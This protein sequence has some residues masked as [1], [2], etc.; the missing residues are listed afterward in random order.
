MT[1]ETIARNAAVAAVGTLCNGGDIQFQ[2]AAGNEVATC[3][4]GATAFGAPSTGT[5]TAAAMGADTSAAGGTIGKA[6]LRKA[7]DSVVAT[8]TVT[9]VGG[10]G[11]LEVTS[12]VVAAG[13][14]V[15]MSPL[16][17]LTQPA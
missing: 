9:V 14:K 2:T 17:T 5:I 1:L 4:F 11:D 8:L 16:P 12:L 3:T 13:E 6:V 10:G 15:E 7:D